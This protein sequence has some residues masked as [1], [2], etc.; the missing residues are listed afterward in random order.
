MLYRIVDEQAEAIE[1]TVGKDFR[2]VGIPL[3]DLRLKSNIL[4]ATIVRS[5]AI[6][7]PDGNDYMD[8][9]DIVVVVT[10]H[11]ALDDLNEILG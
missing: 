4:I 7:I 5:G 1:F 2:G 8:I 6:I 3:K 10:T 11:Y 9:D